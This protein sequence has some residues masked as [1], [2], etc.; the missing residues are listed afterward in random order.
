MR[1]PVVYD[2]EIIAING[3]DYINSYIEKPLSRNLNLK[4]NPKP[5][6]EMKTPGWPCD[7]YGNLQYAMIDNQIVHRPQDAD[8]QAVAVSTFNKT[9]LIK[10]IKALISEIDSLRTITGGVSSARYQKL[11]DL[12]DNIQNGNGG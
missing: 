12:A 2:Y 5:I 8:E 1:K 6:D 9:R 11:K 4:D 10:I 7:E 3:I